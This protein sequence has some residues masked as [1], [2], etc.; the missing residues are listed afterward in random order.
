MEFLFSDK[1]FFMK[2]TKFVQSYF[3]TAPNIYFFLKDCAFQRIYMENGKQ[4][5][6]N[7]TQIQ[8]NKFQMEMAVF[9]WTRDKVPINYYSE[10]LEGLFRKTDFNNLDLDTCLIYK[11]LTENLG[12]F[13]PY[14]KL[15]SQR[16]HYFKNKIEKL[17]PKNSNKISDSY[18]EEG[19]NKSSVN[20]K[21]NPSIIFSSNDL[22]GNKIYENIIAVNFISSDQSINYP[23]GG[24]KS[25]K[26]STIEKKL[27][28]EFPELNSKDIY[29]LA[30]GSK[31]NRALTLEQ[32]KIKTGNTIL[33]QYNEE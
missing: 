33:I 26:F 16:I 32:N 12:A 21:S 28:N 18:S 30:N 4:F 20:K 24:L 5:P 22:E 23:I 7:E 19:F 31:I 9:H 14:D 25:D 10:F 1:E 29:Y 13:G 27:L 6:D 2:Y 3:K 15:T 17:K 8:F 11:A